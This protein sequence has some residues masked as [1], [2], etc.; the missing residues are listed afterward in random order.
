MNVGHAVWPLSDQIV[1]IKPLGVIK[2]KMD[3]RHSRRYGR[4]LV[5]QRVWRAAAPLTPSSDPLKIEN[6]SGATKHLTHNKALP[7]NNL[8]SI[9]GNIFELKYPKSDKAYLDMSRRF[10]GIL[11]KN[12]TKRLI[13]YCGV[14]PKCGKVSSINR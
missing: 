13:G 5:Q 10:K 4:A 9:V 12:N 11:A 6:R 2:G 3:N 1:T 14:A 8:S 7:H